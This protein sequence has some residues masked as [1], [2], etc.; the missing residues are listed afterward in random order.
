MRAACEWGLA[1]ARAL[2]GS[3]D[4]F[5]LVDVLSFS[6]C[7]DIACANGASVFPFAHGD[8]EAA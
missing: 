2:A 7:V 8:R 5:V 6:T 1:G 4:I 3:A